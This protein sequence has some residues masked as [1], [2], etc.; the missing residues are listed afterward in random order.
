MRRLFN[1]RKTHV[2]RRRS[3]NATLSESSLSPPRQ[4]PGT[5]RF[6]ISCL[7]FFL[8]PRRRGPRPARPRGAASPGELAAAGGQGPPRAGVGRA[9]A[10]GAAPARSRGARPRPKQKWQRPRRRA[11]AQGVPG[12]R[13]PHRGGRGQVSGPAPGERSGRPGPAPGGAGARGAGL[14]GPA[15]G[16]SWRAQGRGAP[17]GPPPAAPGSRAA[18][19]GS[20]PGRWLRSHPGPAPLRRSG[21]WAAPA[22]NGN[23]E[24]AARLGV[25]GSRE[26]WRRRSRLLWPL[27]PTWARAVF[28][29]HLRAQGSPTSRGRAAPG[30]SP[31]Y[32]G[33]CGGWRSD[34]TEGAAGPQGRRGQFSGDS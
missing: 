17:S 26:R 6:L 28:A 25:G 9:G 19:A 20:D 4:G 2:C 27:G 22:L 5:G 14:G 33:G 18:T 32:T 13:S 1:V 34:T 24:E 16:R 11:C 15:P 3:I 29:G 23:R 30:T 21:P 12:A 7:S 8:C 10:R 31:Y